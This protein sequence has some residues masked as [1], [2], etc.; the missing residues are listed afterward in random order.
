MSSAPQ[1]N[2]KLGKSVLGSMYGNQRPSDSVDGQG[3]EDQEDSADIIVNKNV[4]RK[5]SYDDENSSSMVQHVQRIEK[6]L[7]KKDHEIQIIKA[8]MKND[9]KRASPNPPQ[10][11]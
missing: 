10:Y 2:F 3:N 8:Q 6:D 11:T 4:D 7:A 1:Q 9:A 5:Y